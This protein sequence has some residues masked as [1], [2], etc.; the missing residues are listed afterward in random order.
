MGGAYLWR[1]QH[2]DTPSA[3]IATEAASFA[4][5]EGWEEDDQRAALACYLRSAGMADAGLPKPESGSIASL[6]ADRE[7]ARRFFEEA[8]LPFRVLADTGLLTSY[9]EPVLKG[10]RA[11]SLGFPIP[12][13]RRPADLRPLPSGHALLTEGLT[14]AR[15]MGG[16][17]EPYFTRA[18]IE[19]GALA[20]RGLEILYL[21]DAIEA[22][23]MHV[24][25][26]GC[27]EL[28]DGS[29]AR[30]TFD[31]KNGHPY[32]SVARCL[33][34]GGLLS[35]KDADLD[36]MVSCLRARHDAG[37][38]LQKN[39]SYIFFK[40]MDPA[41]PGPKGSIGVQLH[42]GRSLAVDPLCHRLGIPIWV[43]APALSFEDRPFRRLTVA[44]DT[45]S[46]IKGAQ[47]GDIF[48][49]QGG[50]ARSVAGRVLHHCEFIVLQPKCQS[51]GL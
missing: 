3:R 34:D 23:I 25:G 50:A 48:A 30:L 18:D 12:V 21:A 8:F 31:G 44:Q 43:S 16:C 28:D 47:R 38:F 32:T 36:G 20:G 13:Y 11:P 19:A 41:E 22:F 29:K 10:S 2:A 4:D 1:W 15:D 33:I 6:L 24:Q 26:S 7:K 45:G 37:S 5:I 9:F 40:E 17:F 35:A 46:A 39:R 49:G 51:A 42:A 27:V 14:A